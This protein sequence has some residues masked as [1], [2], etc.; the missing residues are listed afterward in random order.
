MKDEAEKRLTLAWQRSDALFDVVK[1]QSMLLQPIPWRHPF[2]FYV[3]HLPAFAWNQICRGVLGREP[4][5]VRFDELFSRGVDPDLDTGICHDHPDIPEHWPDLEE[6]LHYRDRVRTAVLNSIED[7]PRAAHR[8]IMAVNGRVLSMV[9]EHECMHQETLLYMVQ[10]LPGEEKNRP[11]DLPDYL[12][13]RGVAPAEVEIPAGDTTLGAS[14]DSLDFGWDNEFPE[15]RARVPGFRI[16][17]TPV[18]NGQFLDF[19]ESGAYD[20]RVYWGQEDWLWK[21]KFDV[22]HPHFWMKREGQWFYRTL[23]DLLELEK[24]FS[25][26]VYVSLAEALAYARWKGKRLPTEAEF[27]RVA[28]CTPRGDECPYPWGRETPAAARGNFNFKYWAP[29]PVG[30]H[31]A[32]CSAWGVYDLAGDGWEWTETPFAP[33]PGFKTYIKTYPEYSADFF[34]GKHYVLKGASWATPVD[35]LRPS[36][37]NWFQARYP[38]VF[39]KFRCAADIS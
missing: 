28:Y 26:P 17:A 5:N 25:W 27:H 13:G 12:V 36:F 19:V 24:V 7:V 33:F 3:G 2:I 18:T 16:D 14:F 6:V 32:G 30:T 4:L 9:L 38:Y 11:A 23:F 34:D 20:N 29:T 8:D 31:S 39:A 1:R 10:E 22:C 21:S 15:R 35:L 37:R